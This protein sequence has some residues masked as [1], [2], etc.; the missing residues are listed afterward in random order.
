MV[1]I[2][3]SQEQGQAIY[4]DIHAIRKVRQG[5]EV[6]GTVGDGCYEG[7]VLVECGS[8]DEVTFV[9]SWLGGAGLSGFLRRC[10]EGL[11]RQALIEAARGSFDG[12]SRQRPHQPGRRRGA[13]KVGEEEPVWRGPS[14]A[15]Q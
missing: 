11:L 3:T 1:Y 8:I 7:E 13:G 6:C 12:L 14:P 4:F 2:G 10:D 15:L 9:D 5:L